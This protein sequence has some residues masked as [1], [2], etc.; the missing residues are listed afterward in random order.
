[1][2]SS[3]SLYRERDEV[4]KKFDELKN[5]L[6]ILPLR[7]NKI[8]T[9]QGL[10]FIFFVSLVIRARVLQKARNAELLD[11]NSIEDI[12]LEL[13]KLRAVKIGGKWRL[14]EISKNRER[15]SKRWRSESRLS[16]TWLLKRAEFR[17]GMLMVIGNMRSCSSASRVGYLWRYSLLF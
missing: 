1:M 6:D 14:T 10:L 17:I 4:E 3:L 9:L 8:E 7:V 15:Y 13:A 2:R 12:L 11:K 5:E 16:Q